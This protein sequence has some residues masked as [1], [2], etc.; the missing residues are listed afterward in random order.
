M[1]TQ[2]RNKIPENLKAHFPDTFDQRNRACNYHAFPRLSPACAPD[3]GG[4]DGHRGAHGL[5]GQ[6][7]G[8]GGQA[9]RGRREDSARAI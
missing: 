5:Q 2:L 4:R 8:Q 1:K 3:V 6:Q 7:G 9:G